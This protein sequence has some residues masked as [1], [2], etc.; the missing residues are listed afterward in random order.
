MLGLY[1]FLLKVFSVFNNTLI[2]LSLSKLKT[3]QNKR[4][5]YKFKF[6]KM[7]YFC[8]DKNAFNLMFEMR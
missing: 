7:C 2:S 3:M 8:S 5:Y 1:L 6:L 4:S